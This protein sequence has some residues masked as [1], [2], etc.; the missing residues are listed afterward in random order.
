M[1]PGR[2]KIAGDSGQGVEAVLEHLGGACLPQENGAPAGGP[3]LLVCRAR[4]EESGRVSLRESEG[5][6]G[7]GGDL[8]LL[9]QCQ[10][11]K[12]GERIVFILH[13]K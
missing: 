11:F 7:W 3:P 6:V 8:S 4:D 2:G 12:G 9:R 1:G 5:G 10:D 13:F